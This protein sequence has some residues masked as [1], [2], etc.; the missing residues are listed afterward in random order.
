MSGAEYCSVLLSS[1]V[2]WRGGV[3]S[4]WERFDFSHDVVEQVVGLFIGFV[5]AMASAPCGFWYLNQRIHDK[6]ERKKKEKKNT[7]ISLVL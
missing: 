1:Y 4:G 2:L 7:L 3:R 5:V 6:T